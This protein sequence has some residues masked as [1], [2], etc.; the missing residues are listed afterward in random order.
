MPLS[1]SVPLSASCPSR[2]F[3]EEVQPHEPALRAYLRVRFPALGEVDDVVQESYTRLLRAQ[4]AGG[5]RYP[6]AFLFTTA[7]NAAL[8]LFRRRRAS[9]LHIVA[10]GAEI[11]LLDEQLGFAEQGEQAYRLEVLADA[12]RALPDRCREVL[13]LR[14]LD[15][16]A[17][18]EIATQLGISPETVT[19][20]MAKGMRRCAE[21]FTERGLLSPAS[22]ESKEA[23]A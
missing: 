9:P 13:M 20:H 7:R 6:K 17:Y 16:L 8:D 22:T 15:G 18:K 12:V 14:Y 4:A 19:V 3:A 21:F 23:S 10:E 2:W 5:V 1:E 11:M